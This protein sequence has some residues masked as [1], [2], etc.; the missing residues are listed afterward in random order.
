MVPSSNVFFLSFAPR[1]IS[2][3]PTESGLW[4]KADDL[5]N[6]K[7]GVMVDHKQIVDVTE[8]IGIVPSSFPVCLFLEPH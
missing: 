6:D 3:G 1:Y 7:V 5:V 2:G 8:D 4:E